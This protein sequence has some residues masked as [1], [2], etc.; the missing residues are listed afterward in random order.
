[1]GHMW[2]INICTV[3]F[4]CGTF[5]MSWKFIQSSNIRIIYTMQIAFSNLYANFVCQDLGFFIVEPSNL[6]MQ[7]FGLSLCVEGNFYSSDE[8]RV[9]KG[10]KKPNQ[11]FLST[12]SI[13]N[14]WYHRNHSEFYCKLRFSWPKLNKL[15]AFNEAIYRWLGHGFTFA[16]N[17]E[18]RSEIAVNNGREK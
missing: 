4:Q 8:N 14:T 1:M 6:L 11:R 9:E 17:N 5:P 10:K 15:S 13:W 2:K 12:N 3:W 7:W 18:E 16:R